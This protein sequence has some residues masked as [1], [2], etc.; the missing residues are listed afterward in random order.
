VSNII[1]LMHGGERKGQQ[2]VCGGGG[3]EWR[4]VAISRVRHTNCPARSDDH[5]DGMHACS[6]LYC[7]RAHIYGVALSIDF[8]LPGLKQAVVLSVGRVR[9]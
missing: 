4:Q 9:G 7:T 3:G 5:E 6:V 2:C 1:K 8:H